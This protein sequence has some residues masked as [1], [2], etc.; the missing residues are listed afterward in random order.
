[1]GDGRDGGGRVIGGENKLS[2][3]DLLFVG[4]Y[5]F[6]VVID[7]NINV[8]SSSIFLLPS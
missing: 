8:I 6:A 2:S 5:G 3:E 1:M 7:S 4:R